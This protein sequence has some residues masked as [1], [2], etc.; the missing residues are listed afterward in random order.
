[1]EPNSEYYVRV[2][3]KSGDGDGGNYHLVLNA[4][5]KRT[6]KP[7]DNGGGQAPITSYQ[8]FIQRLYGHPKGVITQYPKVGHQAIDSVNQ[9]SYPYKVYSLASGS[10]RFMGQDQYGG[11]YIDIWNPKL[12]KTFRYLHFE[13]FNSSLRVGQNISAGTLIG[14]EGHSGYTR[15]A[16]PA[17]RHTHFAVVSNGVQ[18]NP[19]PTLKAIS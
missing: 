3:D 10:I 18:V 7:P 14:V 15:P 16:G 9:G 6:V 1:L 2:K 17:G 12:R 19:W 8:Q 4:E 13:S 5:V 11:K